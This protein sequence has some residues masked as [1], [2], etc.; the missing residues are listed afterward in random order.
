MAGR[1]TLGEV[2][3]HT[4]GGSPENGQAAGRGITTRDIQA[5]ERRKRYQHPDFTDN[6]SGMSGDR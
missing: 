5:Q 1:M 3:R 2:E 4:R 6:L